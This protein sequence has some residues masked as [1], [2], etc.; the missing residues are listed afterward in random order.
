M[1]V[2]FFS[3]SNV[4]IKPNG[5]GLVQQIGAK[6]LFEESEVFKNALLLIEDTAKVKITF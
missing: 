4:V 1:K 3:V 6:P 2:R 5:G